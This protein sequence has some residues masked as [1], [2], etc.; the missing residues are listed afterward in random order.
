MDGHTYVRVLGSGG[1]R[2][3][4]GRPA[5]SLDGE[6]TWSRSC[7]RGEQLPPQLEQGLAELLLLLL[8]LLGA[9]CCSSSSSSGEEGLEG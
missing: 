3:G 4:D 9:P 7:A 2:S 8:L 1:G 5:V 6:R